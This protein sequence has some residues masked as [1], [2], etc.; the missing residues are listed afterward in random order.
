M[1][2]DLWIMARNGTTLLPGEAIKIAKAHDA[3]RQK[4]HDALDE[5][6]KCEAECARLSLIVKEFV[7]QT[8]LDANRG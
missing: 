8:A 3:L 5:L 6:A 2:E 4:Y 1:S 7:G